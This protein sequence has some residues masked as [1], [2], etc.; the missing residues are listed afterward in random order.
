MVLQMKTGLLKL[1]IPIIGHGPTSSTSG[2]RQ[3]WF[4]L[5]WSG[6]R[7]LC[8]HGNEPCS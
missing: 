4:G 1:Y 8:E 3:V 2:W 5:V 6:G 7:L